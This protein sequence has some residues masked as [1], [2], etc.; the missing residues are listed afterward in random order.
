MNELHRGFQVRQYKPWKIWLTLVLVTLLLWLFFILGQIYQSYE[1]LHLKL[2]RETLVSQIDE[3]ESRNHNLV[4]KNAQLSSISRI[5]SS[6]NVLANKALI[7]LQQEL[8]EQ[9]EELVFYQGI[10]SPKDVALGINLQTLE[11]KPKG[12]RG[13]FSYKMVLTKR[14][15]GNKKVTGTVQILIR[16]EDKDGTRE[17]L[18]SE[19]E[20]DKS[21]GDTKFSFRYFQVFEG[22]FSFIEDFEPYELEVSVVS[23]TKKIKSFTES[24]SWARVLSEDS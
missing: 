8:L 6:A 4:K 22:E 2:E 16:G 11:V 3:L 17:F 18:L 14:G 15:E 13:L 1:L 7:K 21:V 20:L 12:S 5:E 9:K 24:I 10:V 23:S 19:I